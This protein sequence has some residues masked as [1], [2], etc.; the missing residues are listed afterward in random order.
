MVSLDV[1]IS[2]DTNVKAPNLDPIE[3]LNIFFPS[4][5]QQEQEF[6]QLRLGESLDSLI[7]FVNLTM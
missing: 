4:T 1:T 5:G 2:K 7:L 3:V 6:L